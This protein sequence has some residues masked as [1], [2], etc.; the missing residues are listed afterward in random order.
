MMHRKILNLK[1]INKEYETVANGL[2]EIRFNVLES[3]DFNGI[4]GTKELEIEVDD[5]IYEE[6]KD[7]IN[8]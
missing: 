8:G 2:L 3:L 6:I 4:D 5:S 1:R 7:I